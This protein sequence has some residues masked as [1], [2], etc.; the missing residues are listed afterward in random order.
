MRCVLLHLGLA[1]ND[2]WLCLLPFSLA[3]R[4]NGL[5]ISKPKRNL[6]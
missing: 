3:R 1:G 4:V 2:A 5:T 6:L